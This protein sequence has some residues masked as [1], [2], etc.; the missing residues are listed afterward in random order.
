MSIKGLYDAYLPWKDEPFVYTTTF[1]KLVG[2][3]GGGSREVQLNEIKNIARHIGV[4]ITEQD[5]K[6]VAD[7]LFGGSGTFRAGK[8]GG[9]KPHFSQRH[10][11]AFKNIAGKLL[12]DLG[13]EQGFDW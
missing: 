3:Q 7:E 13:Y 8:Q 4:T 12:I 5:A 2:P 1:E 6:R 11:D 10:I 9:W